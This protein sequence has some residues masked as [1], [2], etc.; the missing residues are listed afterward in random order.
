MTSRRYR[1]AFFALGWLLLIG[2]VLQRGVDGTLGHAFAAVRNDLASLGQSLS[3]GESAVRANVQPHARRDD[4]ARVYPQLDAAALR[5]PPRVLYG[6]YDGALPDSFSGIT[7]LEGRV[8]RPFAIIS[9][10]QAWG[11]RPD[12]ADFPLRAASTI[13]RLGSV[14]MITWEPWVK[15]FD[16][17][18]RGNLPDAKER[19]YASLAAIAR[20]DYDFY[21]TRWARSAAQ[22]GKPFFLRFAHEM[23]DPYRYPWG[24]QNG[25]RPEDFIAAWRHVHLV[26]QKMSATNAVWVW[27][28]HISMPWFEYYYPGDEWV[29]WVGTGVLNYGDVAPW[30]RWWTFHQIVEKA[31][32]SLTKLGK[33]IMITEFG[34][35]TS[36]GDAA[37]WYEQ[38]FRDMHDKYGAIRAVVLFNQTRDV[39]LSTAPLNWSP[40]Q[41][42]RAARAVAV[43]MR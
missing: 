2:I 42:A 19:E 37:Q 20:G 7:A 34:S 40:L 10:Y 31:Y 35:V 36:G 11:D 28:P 30:S 18:L 14:P 32:P 39:T 33:P 12:E 9:I 41:D 6:A 8:A 43:A 22:Y 17:E 26:F 5:R 29:D 15:D 25:N 16:A 1:A 4:V 3:D 24:P 38:A 27:S 13:D 21:V 23:N